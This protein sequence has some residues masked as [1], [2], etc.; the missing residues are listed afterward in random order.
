VEA[1]VQAIRNFEQREAEFSPTEIQKHARQ[2]D[3]S[4]FQQRFKAFVDNA[5]LE[6][7]GRRLA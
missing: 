4:I 6:Q 2:F 1:V 3:T 5:M 7:S